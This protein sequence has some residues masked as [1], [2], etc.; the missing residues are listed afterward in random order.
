LALTRVHRAAKF[1]DGFG[2]NAEG[3]CMPASVYH[4]IDT[5]PMQDARTLRRPDHVRH[6]Y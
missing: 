6:L 1:G 3:G 5:R 2:G 4:G